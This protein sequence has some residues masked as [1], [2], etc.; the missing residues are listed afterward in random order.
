MNNRY[1]YQPSPLKFFG[2]DDPEFQEDDYFNSKPKQNDSFKR[3]SF[4]NDRFAQQN[5]SFKRDGFGNDRFAQQNDSFKRD[6][7]GNDR[8]AQ[9]ND[10]FKR[11]GF[12]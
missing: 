3:D 9:Q 2:Q 1:N 6:G 5:D 12:G 4:G 11:D 10:S 8:F 7:F